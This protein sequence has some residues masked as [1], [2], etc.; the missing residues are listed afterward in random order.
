MPRL[1]GLALADE[2]GSA[3][4]VEVTGAKAGKLAIPASGKKR[5]LDEDRGRNLARY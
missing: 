4:R 5:G 3:V 1:A 2:D